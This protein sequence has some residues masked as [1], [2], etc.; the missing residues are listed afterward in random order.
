M[1]DHVK[2]SGSLVSPFRLRFD[3]THFNS[4][5]THEIKAIESQVNEKIQENIPITTRITSYERAIK[6]GAVAIFEEKYKEDVRV[7]TVR[8]FSK[9]LCGGSHVENT[10]NIGLF[11]IISEGS[12]A[13]GIRRIEALTG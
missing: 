12:I 1:G 10:G 3:F 9:E 7:V 2:Q 8:D 6:E 11:K 13:A 5:T 4:I